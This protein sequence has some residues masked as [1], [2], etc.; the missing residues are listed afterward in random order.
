MTADVN[1]MRQMSDDVERLDR[2]RE[3]EARECD[4]AIDALAWL[5]KAVPD[6]ARHII[7]VHGSQITIGLVVEGLIARHELRRQKGQ[8]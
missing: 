3:V 8:E 4:T 1:L 2:E 5:L 6:H 7:A